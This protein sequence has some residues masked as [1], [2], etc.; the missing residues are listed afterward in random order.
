MVKALINIEEFKE[1]FKN[2]EINRLIII[3]YTATWCGPC[4]F[5]YPLIEEL[6]VRAQHI[7]IYKVDV[8]NDGD[9]EDEKISSVND[10]SSMPTF[11][12]YKNGNL[13]D[14]LTGANKIELLKKV[15]IHS[16]NI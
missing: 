5:I 13:I 6:D 11:H 9:D 10:I 4:K 1:V 8:D 3:F 14:K 15:K 2:V 7:S 12:F 16:M